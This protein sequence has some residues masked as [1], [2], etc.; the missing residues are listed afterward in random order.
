MLALQLFLGA[1]DVGG[2]EG[3]TTR[4]EMTAVRKLIFEW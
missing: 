2:Y 4:L 1:L 3:S